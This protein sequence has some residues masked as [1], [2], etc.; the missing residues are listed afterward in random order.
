MGQPAY[1]QS[2]WPCKDRPD[3]KFLMTMNLTVPDTLVGVSNGTSLGE[4]AAAPG[5]RTYHW[6]E[7]F[8]IASYLVSVAITDYQLLESSCTTGLGTVVPLQNWVFPNDVAAATVDFAPLCDMMDFCESKFGPYP[9]AGEKYGHAEFLWPGAMEHQTVTSIGASSLDGFGAREWLIVHELGHQWFGDSLTPADWA[10]IWLNEGFATYTEALWREQAGGTAAYDTYMA[11]A[12]HEDEWLA[13]GPVYDPMPIFPGRVIYDKGAWIVHMVRS[14]L[15][16]AAFFGLLKDWTDGATRRFGQVDTQEFIDLAG[17]WAGEDLN[18]FLWPYLT[19]T[20]LPAVSL[21]YE[22]SEGTAGTD[23]HLRLDLIQVQSPLFDNSFPVV[24]TTTAGQTTVLVNLKDAAATADFEMA[25]PII[26]VQLDPR[27]QVLWR[28]A[29]GVASTAGLT[30]AYPNPTRGEYVVFRYRLDTAARPRLQV[31]D[32]MGREV[33][34]RDLGQQPAG[35]SEW[36][37]DVTGDQGSR[38]PSGTYWGALHVDGRRS[39]VRF[40]VVR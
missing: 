9:F 40:T 30:L 15:G 28:S 5:W 7:N 17:A 34:S 3:D 1:A 33:M 19:T 35:L 25:A 11:E 27:Q 37:W 20:V 24:V 26:A 8:P 4:S 13:Q 36:G 12:R 14:R 10:D 38:V 32:L 18:A 29:A 2:W 16:D 22:V 21:T 23:T 6:R 39:V 31:F